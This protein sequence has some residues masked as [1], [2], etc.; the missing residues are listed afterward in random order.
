MPAAHDDV[1]TEGPAHHHCTSIPPRSKEAVPSFG[2]AELGKQS[3]RRGGQYRFGDVLW[4]M[5]LFLG[6]VGWIALL[7]L[8]HG[9]GP[10]DEAVFWASLIAALPI[11]FGWICHYILSGRVVTPADTVLD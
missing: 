2:G 10:I 8:A 9:A 1:A 4:W 6:G 11:G 3:G 7:A 5:G